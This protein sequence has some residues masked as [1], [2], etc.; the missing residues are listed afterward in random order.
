MSYKQAAE[1]LDL[2]V[3]TIENQMGK[4]IK[5]LREF[6]LTPSIWLYLLIFIK[7]IMISIGV[8]AIAGVI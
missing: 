5:V 3:K 2:S 7:Q 6:A 4:A 8:K 1:A